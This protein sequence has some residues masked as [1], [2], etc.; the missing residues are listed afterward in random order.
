[1]EVIVGNYQQLEVI[2]ERD[3]N[4]SVEGRNHTASDFIE[5]GGREKV[6]LI[7]DYSF[8]KLGS[9]SPGIVKVRR[10]YRVHGRLW[11]CLFILIN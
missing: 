6:I 9:K 5:M 7:V 10:E 4:Q 3:F 8:L 2:V 11:V 1:M